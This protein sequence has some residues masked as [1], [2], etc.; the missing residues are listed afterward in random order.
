MS[1]TSV[2]AVLKTRG[3]SPAER[4]ILWA[5]AEVSDDAGYSWRAID[6]VAELAELTERHVRRLVG[7]LR[8][9]NYLDQTYQGGGRGRPALYRVLP[10]MLIDDP[11]A[12]SRARYEARFREAEE[13]GGKMSPFRLSPNPGADVRKGGSPRALKG[14]L[15]TPRLKNEISL[16]GDAEVEGDL[17]VDQRV[18]ELIDLI[19]RDEDEAIGDYLRR[20]HK[21]RASAATSD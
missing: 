20:A 5:F 12:K 2:A 1:S 18:P 19:P 3:L 17:D 7:D 11:D 13:K 16:N 8:K 10:T 15:Q 21:I 14:G 4:V 6:T 9:R